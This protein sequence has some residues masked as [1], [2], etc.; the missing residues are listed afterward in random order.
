MINAAEMRVYRKLGTLS[1]RMKRTKAHIL[2]QIQ[3]QCEVLKK[4][5]NKD[6]ENKIYNKTLKFI[7]EGK[8]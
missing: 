3:V 5:I 6:Q 4:K 2:E 8:I 1:W 7:P